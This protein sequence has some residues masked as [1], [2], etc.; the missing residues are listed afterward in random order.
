MQ[1]ALKMLYS[2]QAVQ[3]K[4]KKG[5]KT[6]EMHFYPYFQLTL[7]SLTII[8]VEPYHCPLHQFFYL[9]KDQ[10]LNFLQ[11]NIEI[12]RSWK[13]TFCFVFCSFFGYWVFQKIHIY[14]FSRWKSSWLSYEVVP[15]RIY[16]S[17][18]A[19]RFLVMFTFQLDN[20][21]R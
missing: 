20:T 3:C 8:L 18:T 16:N 6:Q 4:L 11:K 19:M 14:F 21:K 13:I 12:W 7:D 1:R 2:C 9:P 15:E 17:I 10:S 5:V